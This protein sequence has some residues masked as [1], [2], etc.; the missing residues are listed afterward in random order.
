M[1][2]QRSK[3]YDGADDLTLRILKGFISKGFLS[4]G[5]EGIRNGSNTGCK[6]LGAS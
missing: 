1:A 5:F 4:K 2:A 6:K 3:P